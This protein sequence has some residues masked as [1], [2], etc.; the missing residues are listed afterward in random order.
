MPK[1]KKCERRFNSEYNLEN[2]TFE[3]TFSQVY[4]K[5]RAGISTF[6][7][8]DTCPHFMIKNLYFR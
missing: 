2:E 1:F 7:V 6:L 4:N 3:L 8:L 5:K